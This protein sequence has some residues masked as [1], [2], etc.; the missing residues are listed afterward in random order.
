MPIARMRAA[1]AI[2]PARVRWRG[3]RGKT[4]PGSNRAAALFGSK[5]DADQSETAGYEERATYALQSAGR[6]ELPNIGS[7]A[8]P[9][10][11]H[12]K[13]DDADREYLAAAVKITERAAGEQQRRQ[14]ERVR[15]D[16]P[17]NMG[18]RPIHGRLQSR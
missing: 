17:L 7:K 12:R 16:N 11:G 2:H 10:R 18:D 15:F 4:G 8:A 5:G 3:D 13:Q 9:C 14:E 1:P 6:D